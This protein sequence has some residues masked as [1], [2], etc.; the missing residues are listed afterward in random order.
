VYSA[1]PLLVTPL[2]KLDPL[3]FMPVLAVVGTAV[4]VVLGSLLLGATAKNIALFE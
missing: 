4:S 3:V 2:V 1:L